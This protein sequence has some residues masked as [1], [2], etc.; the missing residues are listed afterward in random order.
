MVS[1]PHPVRRAC[2]AVVVS[3]CACLA[4][5]AFAQT[6]AELFVLAA[7]SLVRTAP[8]GSL[9]SYVAEHSI[10][11]GAGVCQLLDAAMA[12]GDEGRTGDERE[13]IELAERV[14]IPYR[15]ATGSS[16]LVELV[17][18]YRGWT[19]EQRALRRTAK[20]LERD[21]ATAQVE[22]R[23]GEQREILHRALEIYKSIGD[24]YSEAVVWGTLGVAAFYE[25]DF[26]SVREYYRSALD[27][28]RRIE[29]NI[30][31]GRTLNGLGTAALM[32]EDFRDAA[33]FY[34]EAIE[35]RRATGDVGGL[36]TSLTYLG[37]A[38]SKLG[39]LA[40]ARDAYEEAL[41]IVEASG[42]PKQRFELLNGIAALQ[43]GMGRTHDANAMYGRAVETA[44]ESG[45]AAGEIIG[46]MNLALTLQS[47]F[48]YRDSLAELDRVETLLRENPDPTQ[49]VLLHRNR[50][51][52]YL[53]MGELDR[54]REDLLGYL[55]KARESGMEGQEIEAMIKLGYLYRELGASD[56]G[57]ALADSAFVRAERI[58]DRVSAREAL[59]LAAQLE[60]ARGEADAAAALYGQTLERDRADGAETNVLEDE[61]GIA[62]ATA[63]AERSVEARRMFRLLEP[64]IREAGNEGFMLALSF[65]IGHSFERENPDSARLYYDRAF[66]LMER[67][68]AHLGGAEFGS[69]YFGGQRRHYAEEVARY[70]ARVAGESGERR[71][72]SEAF[73]TIE[74]AKARGLLDLLEGSLAREHSAAEDAVLDSI[75]RL[76]PSAPGY[77]GRQRILERRYRAVRD[78]R[79][80]SAAA[81]LGTYTAVFDLE[82]VGKALPRG[83]VLFAYAVGDSVSLLWAADRGGYAIYE[84]PGRSVLRDDVTMLRSALAARGGADAALRSYARKLFLTLLSPAKEYLAR[85]SR[86]VIVPDDCLFEI[87]FE[88]LLSAETGEETGWAS[89]PFLA[90]SHRLVY[91]PSASIYFKLR[92]TDSSPS[93]IDLVAAGDPDYATG[94]GE[95]A[96]ALRPLPHSRREVEEIGMNFKED[97]RLLLVG[98]EATEAAL[99]KALV[100][101]RPR[102]LHLAAHGLVDPVNPAASSIA[103][104]ADEAGREDGY[105]HTLEILAAPLACR[106]VTLSACESARGRI[107]RGEGVVGLSRAFLAAGAPCVVSSLWPVSDEST[108]LLM[109]SF[110]RSMAKRKRTAVEALNEARLELMNTDA[111]GHPFHWAAFIA[112]GSDRAP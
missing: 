76:D 105:F 62:N 67:T 81:R 73:R 14:A 4:C 65:G 44:V 32:R 53:E 2:A 86:C 100:E 17:G 92:E 33:G 3:L 24:G 96:A 95:R 88:A 10:L 82:R 61:L 66:E 20:T 37:N 109:R 77:A 98:R 78:A 93:G 13:N 56:R 26:A 42:T 27:A 28:R 41:V 112:I 87:P 102:F 52:A 111:Y 104:I 9:A 5:A 6:P 35:L 40:D 71:W 83:T 12:A 69:A 50:G 101:R 103:L 47:A 46:R 48:R 1:I 91:A 22:K 43:A 55:S 80:E 8:E 39:L 64:R 99:K 89:C 107:G 97:R 16:A 108:S 68:R 11:A 49:A 63:L 110:Y 31:V 59:L 106:I 85:N 19:P 23:F 34:R 29:N 74:R 72:I 75:Y 25:G 38:Y 84:I 60:Q 57:R 15:D 45:D 90:K 7:D 70:Y 18:A 58:G 21:A 51:Q 30:L 54:A 36:G 79:L 94:G